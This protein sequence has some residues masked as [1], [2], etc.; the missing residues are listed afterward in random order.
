MALSVVKLRARRPGVSEPGG[1]GTRPAQGPLPARKGA[2]CGVWSAP[3]YGWRGAGLATDWAG[4]Q[5]LGYERACP[6]GGGAAEG[7]G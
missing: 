4:N 3:L 7:G 5:S 1:G 6:G 2:G